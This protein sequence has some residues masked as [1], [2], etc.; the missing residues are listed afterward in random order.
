MVEGDYGVCF[1]PVSFL[2]PKILQ[3]YQ[4]FVILDEEHALESRLFLDLDC[5]LLRRNIFNRRGALYRVLRVVH[6]GVERIRVACVFSVDIRKRYFKWSALD[7]AYCGQSL[8]IRSLCVV[9]V[10]CDLL[11]LV[12]IHPFYCVLDVRNIRGSIEGLLEF[13]IRSCTVKLH[14]DLARRSA[15][16]IARDCNFVYRCIRV[17]SWEIRNGSCHM[18]LNAREGSRSVD[19]H[20]SNLIHADSETIR[21]YD[22]HWCWLRLFIH[23]VEVRNVFAVEEQFDISVSES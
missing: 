22:D 12:D 6:V 23:V 7:V 11:S 15:A 5:D 13:E 4:C 1:S 16:W 17:H 8:A 9:I 18:C 20:R 3:V 19:I 2:V 10:Q 14:S 21:I